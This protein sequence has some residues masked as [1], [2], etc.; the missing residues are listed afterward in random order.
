MTTKLL[1]VSFLTIRTNQSISQ[2]LL[3]AYYVLGIVLSAKDTE[4]N[5]TVIYSNFK[6]A[7]R[8]KQTINM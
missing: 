7:S 2:Y 3:S 8:R 5:K 6:G 1:V 4:M